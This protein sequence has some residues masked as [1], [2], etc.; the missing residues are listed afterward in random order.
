MKSAFSNSSD[1]FPKEQGMQMSFV[2]FKNNTQ[3]VEYIL[4][5]YS[6][7]T[8]PVDFIHLLV[9]LINP[10]HSLR[11][12]FLLRSSPGTGVTA[13]NKIAKKFCPGRGETIKI[14]IKIVSASDK[15]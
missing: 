6:K 7:A 10:S 11:T 14:T 3:M 15:S 5:K 13:G 1:S 9:Y 2:I 8:H 12:H 4:M